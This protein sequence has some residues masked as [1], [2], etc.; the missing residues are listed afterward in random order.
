MNANQGD[1]RKVYRKLGISFLCTG[2][3][4]IIAAVLSSLFIEQTLAGYAQAQATITDTTGVHTTVSYMWNDQIVRTVLSESNSAWRTGD[5]ITVFYDPASPA[6]VTTGMLGWLLPLIFCIIGGVFLV[7]GAV[8]YTRCI[9][10]RE[11][12]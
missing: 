2:A 3:L 12:V 6:T 9:R 8:F 5:E 1:N 7:L 11:G 10:M 4:L